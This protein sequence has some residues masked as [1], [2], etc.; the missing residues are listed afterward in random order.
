MKP[1]LPRFTASRA[2]WEL[3]KQYRKNNKSVYNL[4]KVP[5]SFVLSIQATGAGGRGIDAQQAQLERT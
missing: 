4:R 1:G 2:T 5:F 3:S